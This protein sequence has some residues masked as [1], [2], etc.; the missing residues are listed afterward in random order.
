MVVCYILQVGA[1]YNGKIFGIPLSAQT[2]LL[3]YRRDVFQR[4]NL[5]VPATWEEVGCRCAAAPK[6]SS[7]SVCLLQGA[8]L[9]QAC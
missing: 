3:T 7:L 5:T 6:A 8:Y 9:R 2:P 1:A 4:Y